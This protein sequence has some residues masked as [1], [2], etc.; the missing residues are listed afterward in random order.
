MNLIPS[1]HTN[2][3]HIRMTHYPNGLQKPIIRR[4]MS[5]FSSFGT[6]ITPPRK[7]AKS[8]WAGRKEWK[9]AHST[10]RNWLSPESIITITTSPTRVSASR[11]WTTSKTNLFLTKTKQTGHAHWLPLNQY[12]YLILNFTMNQPQAIDME[13][14]VLSACLIETTAMH[15]GQY[16]N[17]SR[18]VLRAKAPEG[19]WCHAAHE[20]PGHGIDILT[21]SEGCA[22]GELEQ[23]G[24][25]YFITQLS[26]HV[27]TPRTWIITCRWCTKSLS[28]GNWY[29]A[30]TSCLPCRPMKPWTWKT[31]WQKGTS[32][33]KTSKR[34]LDATPIWGNSRCLWPIPCVKPK[35]VSTM[36]QE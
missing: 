31:R 3:T 33:S 23:I 18:N 27:P 21:V 13:Q 5:C 4:P 19:V 10:K 20:H 34:S 30:S 26:S 12:S 9:P 36:P 16:Q 25:P 11:R 35:D 1:S 24:G 14:A 7:R 2:L 8:T 32:C 29:W 15:A 22:G 28:A 6:S 17:S